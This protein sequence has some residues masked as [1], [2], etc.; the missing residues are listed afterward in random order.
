MNSLSCPLSFWL[1]ENDSFCLGLFFAFS[2][3]FSFIAKVK[4][5]LDGTFFFQC[6]INGADQKTKLLLVYHY[7]ALQNESRKARHVFSWWF[8]RIYNKCNGHFCCMIGVPCFV[9]FCVEIVCVCRKIHSLQLR[10]LLNRTY[11]S[12]LENEWFAFHCH[13]RTRPSRQQREFF[14]NKDANSSNPTLY[15][16][17]IHLYVHPKWLMHLQFENEKKM[18]VL[19]KWFSI[20]II[21]N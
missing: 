6:I 21:R 2:Q 17:L 1:W 11:R 3:F 20:S 12:R 15:H 5:T 14:S 10:P 18:S 4:C 16:V 19:S 7:Y 8:I 13:N 9:L